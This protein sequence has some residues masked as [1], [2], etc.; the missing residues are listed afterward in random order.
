MAQTLNLLFQR[1]RLIALA[2]DG[3]V[4]LAG[5]FDWLDGGIGPKSLVQA[6]E[7]GRFI[8]FLIMMI[9]LI[10]LELKAVGEDGFAI[11]SKVELFPFLSRVFLFLGACSVT[12]LSYSK[13]IFLPILLYCYL[14]VSEY[15]SY[16]MAVSAVAILFGLSTTTL[17]PS[18]PPPPPPRGISSEVSQSST[19]ISTSR[20]APPL[21]DGRTWIRRAQGGNLLD[22][23]MGSLITLF[24]T[25]LLARAMLQSL[26]SQQKLTGLLAS[27]EASHL[28]LKQYSSQVAE[29]AATEER[30]RLARDIHD[31]LGHHLAA[32]NI[33]LEKANAYRE[34][35]PNRSHNALIQAKSTVQD[36]LKDVRESVGSLRENGAEFSFKTSLHELVRRMSHSELEL[37]VEQNG[38]SSRYSK[39]QL[40]TLYR[41]VQEGLTNVHRHANA[42]QVKIVLQFGDQQATLDIIDNGIGFDTTGW[43]DSRY[44][45]RIHGLQ[46]LQERLSL[47]G[48]TLR[49]QS[50]PQE[51]ILMSCIPKSHTQHRLNPG[52]WYDD[53]DT[54]SAS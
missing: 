10:C 12:D 44:K 15:L 16:V 31:S 50:K 2:V 38:D 6:P 14:A 1:Y 24:F 25:L 21:P 23:S 39:L 32:I 41:V 19:P 37:L 26:K 20:S 11:S 49:I 54:N 33:Q 30:N 51:T 28:Q 43:D 9:A 17:I 36:A 4:L 18:M 42:S 3:S 13:I 53:Q 48:G 40:M 7:E 34:I 22:K 46:G 35:D 45:T 52:K 29:L 5:F 47:L 27:L 8:T